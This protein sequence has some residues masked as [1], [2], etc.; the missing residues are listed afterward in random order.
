MRFNIYWTELDGK[1][2]CNKGVKKAAILILTDVILESGGEIT[3]I[4]DSSKA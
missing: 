2:Y 1:S 3:G 4:I